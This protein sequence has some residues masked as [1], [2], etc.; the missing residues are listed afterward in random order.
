MLLLVREDPPRESSSPSGTDCFLRT[1]K[2]SSKTVADSSSS[3]EEA[4]AEDAECLL[5]G[6][7]SDDDVDGSGRVMSEECFFFLLLR[8]DVGMV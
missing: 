5:L 8:D 4:E 1:T 7:E 6:M 3:D 2:A